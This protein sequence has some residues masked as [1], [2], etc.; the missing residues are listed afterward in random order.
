LKKFGLF[1]K[2]KY[3][4]DISDKDIQAWIAFLKTPSPKEEGLSAK[5]VSR[6]LS[7]LS[8]YFFGF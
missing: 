8:N 7:A 1:L 2:E 6:K 4:K 3:V 5:T